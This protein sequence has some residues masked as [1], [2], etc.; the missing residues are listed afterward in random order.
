[1]QS[2]LDYLFNYAINITTI[3][4]IITTK[5]WIINEAIDRNYLV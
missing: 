3:I 5:I 4:I 1:M 2:A